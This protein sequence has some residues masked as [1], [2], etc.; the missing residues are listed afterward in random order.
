[1]V[2]ALPKGGLKLKMVTD[3][4]NSEGIVTTNFSNSN[5]GAFFKTTNDVYFSPD[6]VLKNFN[7]RRSFLAEATVLEQSKEIEIR[8]PNLIAQIDNDELGF[9]ALIERVRG[10]TLLDANLD[11]VCKKSVVSQ[12]V[13]SLARFE[14]WS[15][16]RPIQQSAK[17]GWSH[18][19]GPLRLQL[20]EIGFPKLSESLFR[21]ATVADEVFIDTR[22]VNCMD[23][24]LGNMLLG[25]NIDRIPEITHIDFDKSWRL[26]PIGEQLSH[27]NQVPEYQEYY[28][29]AQDLYCELSGASGKNLDDIAP[30]SSFF[31]AISGIRDCLTNTSFEADGYYNKLG[32]DKRNYLL[33]VYLKNA[34]RFSTTAL[35]SLGFSESTVQ[36]IG[37][38]L[39]RL[40]ETLE[41]HAR[42]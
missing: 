9:W 2:H 3:F 10:P 19:L 11:C 41:L 34:F 7:D 1:M 32:F 26:V 16:K 20:V 17:W 33:K 24:Y 29:Y 38:D 14:M 23:I 37:A 22:S 8:T 12:I 40:R 15:E 25:E 18:F 27:L 35:S 28:K 5:F 4:L 6:H 39:I 42:C 31:R 21:A 36:S 30:I 13:H